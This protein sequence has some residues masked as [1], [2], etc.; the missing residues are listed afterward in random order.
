MTRANH[1]P[2]LE[3]EEE[4][5]AIE[6][7]LAAASLGEGALLLIEGEAGIGKSRLLIETRARAHGHGMRCLTAS[8]HD[9]ES[10]FHFGLALQL[11]SDVPEASGEP[12][13]GRPAGPAALAAPLLDGQDSKRLTASTEALFP[14]LYGLYWLV[15][16]L[17]ERGPVLICVDD[18]QWADVASLESLNF[19]AERIEGLGTAMVVTVRAGEGPQE[20]VQHLRRHELTRVVSPAPLSSSALRQLVRY[21]FSG[22]DDSFCTA[23]GQASGGNPFYLHSLLAEVDAA[24]RDPTR[25]GSAAISDL[26]PRAVEASVQ[27]QLERLPEGAERFAEAVAVLGGSSPIAIARDLARLDEE[28]ALVIA[29]RMAEAGLLREGEPVSFAHPLVGNAVYEGIPAARRAHD[30]RRAA[31]LLWN[32]GERPERVGAQ[33]LRAERGAGAWARESL[34]RAAGDAA[35]RGAPGI[36]R[37]YLL[38]AL[39]EGPPE[40]ERGELTV[41]LGLAEAALGAD[42]AWERLREGLRKIRSPVR[43]AKALRDFAMSAFGTRRFLVSAERLHEEGKAVAAEDSELGAE[44]AALAL[45][46]EAYGLASERGEDLERMQQILAREELAHTPAGRTLLGQAAMTGAAG[47]QSQSEVVSFARR[48]IEGSRSFEDPDDLMVAPIAANA[49]TL[50]DELAE[51]EEVLSEALLQAQ[52]AGRALPFAVISHSRAINRY[53]GGSVTGAVADAERAVAGY[54]HGWHWGLPG[55]HAYLSQAL[56]ERGEIDQAA[57]ALELPEGEETWSE[58]ML[59][60]LYLEARGR[61]QLERGDVEAALNDFM[62]IGALGPA[63]GFE[64]PAVVP[65]RARASE[66]VRA[67][68][69][70]PEALELATED[71]RRA[72]AFGTP[73]G[74]G[75]C[76]RARGLAEEGETALQWLG[77]AAE[78]L[79]PSPNRLEHARVQV[80]LG[81]SL[82]RMGRRRQ[83]RE[84]LRDG[85]E[86]AAECEAHALVLRAEE[87]LGASGARMLRRTQSGVQALTPSERRVAEMAAGGMSNKE[88]AA[89]LFLSLRTV[90]THLTRTYRKLGISSR[91]RLNEALGRA[92]NAR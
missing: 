25:D 27:A 22:A 82:R 57:A 56:L 14:L 71:L 30:H 58:S 7:A 55:S 24:G 15:V 40:R 70:R 37:D 62:R 87:E 52:R 59:M 39:E 51:A 81:A 16:S 18:A 13:E 54:A 6:V 73:W 10:G 65:W 44:L 46:A 69:R 89:A 84:A 8:G 80:D 79:A 34:A 50:V 63:A 31:E 1:G 47:G 61:L 88:I 26:R 12:G 11:F 28:A 90:E 3:R 78:V 36:A 9:L 33:L 86:L 75:V 29:D 41:R 77:E 4:L 68:G 92:P 60:L 38:R 83:A 43:R 2:L 5:E 23:C 67:L 74:L 35:S 19:L 32:R 48:A 72:R 21:S 76:L 17:C 64:N 91:D 66:A 85:I 45:V 42:G 20:L 49:L 53:R